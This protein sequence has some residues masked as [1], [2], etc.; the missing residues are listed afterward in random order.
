MAD[1]LGVEEGKFTHRISPRGATRSLSKREVGSRDSDFT[2]DLGQLG[3]ISTANPESREPGAISTVNPESRIPGAGGHFY[4]ESRTGPSVL[5]FLPRIPNS[6]PGRVLPQSPNRALAGRVL[7]RTPKR[8]LA[9][10]LP[11]TPNGTLGFALSTA[12]PEDWPRAWAVRGGFYRESRIPGA[13]EP[14]HFYRESRTE[15]GHRPFLPRIPNS[16]PARDISTVNPEGTL[17]SA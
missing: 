12:N 1:P 6:G 10:F 11:Q 15:G 4:R 14:G 13:R 5:R 16:G 17:H 8:G 3:G 9:A 7:P 2:V